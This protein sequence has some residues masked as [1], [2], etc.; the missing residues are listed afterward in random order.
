[1]TM[2]IRKLLC[3]SL[4]AA[5]VVS[6]VPVPAHAEDFRASVD[7]AAVQL[8][9]QQPAK[10]SSSQYRRSEAV[11]GQTPGGGG[12]G[13]HTALVVGVLTTVVSLGATYY[14]VKQL[15]KETGQQ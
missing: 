3:T 4:A 15:K 8:A 1:M 14:V 10:R 11:E 13:G 7:R 12:G 2:T 9:R 5:I 6:A